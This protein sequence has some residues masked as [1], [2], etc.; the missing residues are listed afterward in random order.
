[1]QPSYDQYGYTRVIDPISG[2]KAKNRSYINAKG[3]VISR[4]EHMRLGGVIPEVKALKRYETGITQKRPLSLKR[5]E[6]ILNSVGKT[7]WI[8]P[9][10][11]KFIDRGNPDFK[12]YWQLGV[13]I[14][15]KCES[16]QKIHTSYGFS[17]VSVKKDVGN[18]MSEAIAHAL[19]Q[20]AKKS[21]DCEFVRLVDYKWL[22]W[23]R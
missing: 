19:A 17:R 11:L 1:M 9:K 14:E 7:K 21:G 10:G 20:N 2:V 6:S 16:K 18:A 13:T 5:A 15:R 23:V 12:R 3:R 8:I 4:R 22:R